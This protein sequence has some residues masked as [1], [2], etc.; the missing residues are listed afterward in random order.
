MSKFAKLSLVLISLFFLVFISF[1][2]L[3]KIDFFDTNSIFDFII[4]NNSNDSGVG[5]DVFYKKGDNIEYTFF[6]KKD[7]DGTISINTDK[8]DKIMK[9][10][11]IYIDDEKISKD[12]LK[13]IKINDKKII[14]FKGTAL[15]DNII[16]TKDETV[17]DLVDINIIKEEEKKDDVKILTGALA[18]VKLSNLSFNSNINNLLIISGDNLGNIQYVNI[19]GKTFTPKLDNNKLYIG[20]DKDSFASGDYF[21]LFQ[22]KNNQI[23][24]YQS[25]IKF[26]YDSNSINISQIT[27]S[28]IKNDIDRYLVI[29]GNNLSKVIRVQLSNN[30]I[31]KD[32]S[33]KVI[34]NNV[35]TIKIP[36]GLNPGNYFINFMGT[37]G[38]FELKNSQFTITN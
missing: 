17:D 4:K 23:Q 25:K 11:D 2:E 35:I 18:N 36:A 19:G 7:F 10:Y 3:R 20:I 6:M 29:Q 24:T 13:N 16:K 27:P 22:L 12:D 28:S 31:L 14:K 37:Q 26:T 21:L 8:L 1:Y 30:V 38:I 15:K 32:T 33:F 34:N 5:K 9:D